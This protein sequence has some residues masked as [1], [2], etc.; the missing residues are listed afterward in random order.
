VTFVADAPGDPPLSP[1]AVQFK[2][3]PNP[4]V[5]DWAH[6]RSPILAGT[7]VADIRKLEF[8]TY[9]EKFSDNTCPY[10]SPYVV[11]YAE[12]DGIDYILVSMGVRD[13]LACET[14]QT[15]EAISQKW[16]LPVPAAGNEFAPVEDPKPLAESLEKFP[17]SIVRNATT[18]EAQCS[19][20]LGG[21]RLEYG[22]FEGLGTIGEAVVYTSYLTA[23]TDNMSDTFL[24]QASP[25]ARSSDRLKPAMAR[26]EVS[27]RAISFPD[28]P[29]GFRQAT[30][31]VE[32][33]GAPSGQ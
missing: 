32:P 29:G 14:W 17:G 30:L 10:V 7:P 8:S 1:G 31:A 13:P 2:V 26:E 19:T 33:P 24:F 12:A 23:K 20:A 3:G 4:E 6:L 21:L 27:S 16:F 22:E 15:V 28:P 9:V 5:Q 25:D 18:L 11:L